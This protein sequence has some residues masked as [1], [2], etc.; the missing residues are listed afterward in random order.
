MGRARRR[1][2]DAA[3]LPP[4]TMVHLGEARS[5]DIRITV[6][7]YTETDLETREIRAEDAAAYRDTKTV[8]WINVDGIHQ[9]DV[10]EK[11]GAAFGL[12]PLTLEDI[13]STRQR[14]KL[15]EFDD[16]LY[17]VLRM[18]YLDPA[19][20]RIED[21]QISIV[22]KE[23]CVISFQERQGDVFDP[24]RERL[25]HNKGRIRK[26]TAGY[27]AY[28]LADAIV[29]NCF[30][31]LEAMGERIDQLEDDVVNAAEPAVLRRVHDLKRQLVLMRKA[32]WPLR[33][34]ISALLRDEST[35]IPP[36]TAA[37]LRDLYDHVIQVVDAIETY[38]EM[39]SGMLDIYL[40]SVSNRMNEV[41]KVL[42]IIA[43]IF[44]P[45][46]FIAGVYGMNF[47]VMPE[48]EW[49]YGYVAVWGVMIA[50]FISMIIYFR[51]KKWL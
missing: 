1:H 19:S 14:P 36:D 37:Y 8:T 5:E 50:V 27:L 24:I 47:K 7:D 42:T 41:M 2:R 17:L 43:T 29:D 4:G 15:E 23:G 44:I 38:R 30:A 18:P 46:T 28:A 21:E 9:I 20:D 33:E 45:L 26:M 39:A 51:R 13:V 40:S 48:L 16:Y 3:G 12:H 11:L 49:P 10:I 31:I 32:I 35:L 22:L 25:R 34:V 6:F